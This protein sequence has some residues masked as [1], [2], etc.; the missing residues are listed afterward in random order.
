[1]PVVCASTQVGEVHDDPRCLMN[2]PFEVGGETDHFD[3]AVRVCNRR[4]GSQVVVAVKHAVRPGAAD[5]GVDP[6]DRF[7]TRGRERPIGER[8]KPRRQDRCVMSQQHVQALRADVFDK[9]VHVRL[10]DVLGCPPRLAFN[11][12]RTIDRH[13][14][15]KRAEP[16]PCPVPHGSTVCPHDSFPHLTPQGLVDRE[17]VAGK[18]MSVVVPVDHQPTHP[19][20]SGALIDCVE[21]AMVDHRPPRAPHHDR[22]R[23]E[24]EIADLHHNVTVVPGS[25]LRQRADPLQIAVRVSSDQQPTRV[26]NHELPTPSPGVVTDFR[27]ARGRRPVSGGSG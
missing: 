10:A 15:T 24:P 22:V 21:P 19:V 12:V 16:N 4:R 5:G 26:H 8:S 11:P 7:R 27:G 2:V 17:C 9:P 1:M 20:N 3:Q 23:P 13:C 18:R 25:E 6:T 14:T